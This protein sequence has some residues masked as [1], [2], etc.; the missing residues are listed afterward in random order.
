MFTDSKNVFYKY[1]VDLEF[2]AHEHNYER[3]W[4]IYDKKVFNESLEELY[5]TPKA[6]VHIITGFA[7]SII[8]VV[9][10]FDFVFL[11]M[12]QNSQLLGLSRISH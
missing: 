12:L 4:P 11:E 7:V 1:G 2:W 3:L 8:K 10:L 5:K 6:P 9:I